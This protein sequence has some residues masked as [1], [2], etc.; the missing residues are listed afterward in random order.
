MGNKVINSP[1]GTIAV[2]NQLVNVDVLNNLSDANNSPGTD[3]LH[4]IV[5]SFLGGLISIENYGYGSPAANQEGSVYLDAHNQSIPQSGIPTEHLFN[6][7]NEEIYE[8]KNVNRV[9]YRM[10]NKII[11]TYP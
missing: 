11:M 3:I 9:E 8:Y 7:N 5:E 4:E 6:S 1:N 10:N 2:T